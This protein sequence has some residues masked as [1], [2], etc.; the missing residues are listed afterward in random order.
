MGISPRPQIGL[1]LVTQLG[2]VVR[3]IHYGY[4]YDQHVRQPTVSR[5]FHLVSHPPPPP[6][7]PPLLLFPKP[8]IG[9]DNKECVMQ[10]SY[11]KRSALS[12]YKRANPLRQRQSRIEPPHLLGK[13]IVPKR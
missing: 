4:I 11:Q 2:K 9:L 10:R 3:T 8:L 7:S 1:T 13:N 5:A 12:E 6:P